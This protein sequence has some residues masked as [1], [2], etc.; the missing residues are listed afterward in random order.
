M[1]REDA[2][3]NVKYYCLF[4]RCKCDRN[5]SQQLRDISIGYLE[6]YDHERERA[7]ILVEAI[8][9]AIDGP[10]IDGDFYVAVKQAL[11]AY[12]EEK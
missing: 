1:N 8:K 7:K 12:G 9:K 5:H 3:E 6:A 10:L 2:E 11:E 4:N